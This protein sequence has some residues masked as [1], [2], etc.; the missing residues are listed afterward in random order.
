MMKPRDLYLRRYDDLMVGINE[1]LSVL[2]SE[3][4]SDKVG[5]M[6]IN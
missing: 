6:E 4:S 1:Y 2:P 3:Q 5:D